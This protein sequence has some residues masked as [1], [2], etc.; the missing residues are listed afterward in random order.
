VAAEFAA[1]MGLTDL[2]NVEGG[3]L[4]W[5]AAGYPVEQ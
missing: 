2:Y 3:T 5:I 1:T 4:A